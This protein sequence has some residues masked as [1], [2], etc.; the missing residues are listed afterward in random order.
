M[1]TDFV[2]IARGA[3]KALSGHNAQSW[4]FHFETRLQH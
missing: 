3:F 1:I 2:Q 4:K